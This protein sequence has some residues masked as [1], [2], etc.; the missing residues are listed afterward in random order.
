MFDQPGKK[1]KEYASWMFWVIA[2]LVGFRLVLVVME[3]AQWNGDA[4]AL[5]GELLVCAVVLLFA[6]LALLGL[7]VVGDIAEE[8]SRQTKLFEQNNE[9]LSR[10]VERTAG[11]PSGASAPTP[12]PGTTP[13]PAT[14][15]ETVPAPTPAPVV[16]TAQASRSHATVRCPKCGTPQGDAREKCYNCGTPLKS[17]S[18]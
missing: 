1:I 6:Y 16:I 9:L 8:T 17:E 2:A 12:E 10:L 14:T 5:P 7:Y 11:A 18:E 3:A 4:S 13:A 15:P